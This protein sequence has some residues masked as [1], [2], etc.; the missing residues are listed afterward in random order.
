MDEVYL[1]F[2]QIKHLM[3]KVLRQ[4]SQ[5]SGNEK[6]CY[7]V[8]SGCCAGGT[9]LPSLKEKMLLKDVIP[10]V[11]FIRV[12]PKEWIDGEGIQLLLE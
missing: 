11:I 3:L 1:M 4:F 2:H 6:T 10:H 5:T 8:V 7:T 9:K 12:H